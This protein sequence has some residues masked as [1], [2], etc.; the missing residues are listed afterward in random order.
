M[1]KIFKGLYNDAHKEHCLKFEITINTVMPDNRHEKK[2]REDIERW[3][4]EK[5]QVR[6]AAFGF[7]IAMMRRSSSYIWP[8]GLRRQRRQRVRHKNKTDRSLSYCHSPLPPVADRGGGVEG[9]EKQNE[10]IAGGH[11]VRSR[12]FRLAHARF[13]VTRCLA[14]A[15]R[16]HGL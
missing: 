2:T 14:R 3:F 6:L 4:T 15:S 1:S 11:R 16:L 8:T 7:Y 10:I 12:F 5:E 9:N 13:I